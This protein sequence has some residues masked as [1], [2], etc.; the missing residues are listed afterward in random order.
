[1]MIPRYKRLE[2]EWEQFAVG[3][4]KKA[5][6]ADMTAKIITGFQKKL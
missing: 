4:I 5:I 3:G 1:M 6:C 2:I